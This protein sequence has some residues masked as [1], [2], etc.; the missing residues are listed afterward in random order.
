MSEASGEAKVEA[1]VDKAKAAGKP[2]NPKADDAVSTLGIPDTFGR[3]GTIAID[4]NVPI[5]SIILAYEAV[6]NIADRICAKVRPAIKEGPVLIHNPADF[7][8]IEDLKVFNRQADAALHVMNVILAEAGGEPVTRE[9]GHAAFAGTLAIAGAVITSALQL[10][11]LVR[12]DHQIKN[13]K[14]DVEDQ[15]LAMTVAGKL[16]GKNKVYNTALMPIDLDAE[17][18]ESPSLKR[19]EVMKETRARLVAAGAKIANSTDEK[20]TA[21]YRRIVEAIKEFDAFELSLLKADEKSGISRM[22]HFPA[23]EAVLALLN[24]EGPFILWLKAVAAGGGVHAKDTA[25]FSDLTYSGGALAIYALY[26]KA[27]V[28]Q[29]AMPISSYAGI[30]HLR[31]LDKTAIPKFQKV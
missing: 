25:V 23:A 14:V 2:A 21:R 20:E 26:D 16:A 1:D 27:G 11:S 17:P 15:V 30:V 19:L 29:E 12:A 13:Y 7:A 6:D 22:A 24:T 3:K 28:L 18:K 5:E 4:E 10:L 31:D 8:A 9:T